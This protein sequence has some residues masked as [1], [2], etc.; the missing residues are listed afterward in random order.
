[1]KGEA[2]EIVIMVV[3]SVVRSLLQGPESAGQ[4]IARE[5][6]CE[7]K[8]YSAE[9]VGKRQTSLQGGGAVPN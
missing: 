9:V 1:M 8:N 2:Q 7:K 3:D 4:V 5:S 6:L